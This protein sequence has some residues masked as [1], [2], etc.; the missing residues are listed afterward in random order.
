MPS[1]HVFLIVA[2]SIDGLIG[3]DPQAPSTTWTSTADKKFFAKRT[4]QAGV[5]VMGRKTYQTIG[6]ALPERTTIVMTSQSPQEIPSALSLNTV[7]QKEQLLINH[8]YVSS[9]T[10]QQIVEKVGSLGFSELAVCGGTSVYTQFLEAD[11]IDTMYIT[12]EPVLF[13][14]GIPFFQP[15]A[16][17]AKNFQLKQATPIDN[18]D[19]L[20]LEYTRK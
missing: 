8:P 15:E 4:K 10:P 12:V 19:A 18:S 9:L 1:M 20:L 11:L 14:K 5:M 17:V 7:Q 13:G 16:G 2:M 6:R 3:T